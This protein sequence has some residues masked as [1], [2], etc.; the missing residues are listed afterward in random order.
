MLHDV[1]SA[2]L[3]N[4]LKLDNLKPHIFICGLPRSGTTILMR[5][6]YET[7][8]FASL[9]Y[10]DMPLLLSPNLWNKISSKLDIPSIP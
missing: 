6:L 2:I 8:K 1:E 9:T 7:K 4:K 5:S 3:K 10:R